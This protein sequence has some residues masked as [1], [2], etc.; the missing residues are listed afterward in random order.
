MYESLWSGLPDWEQISLPAQSGNPSCCTAAA[1]VA[2]LGRKRNLLQS[3]NPG[4]CNPERVDCAVAWGGF[5]QNVL[6]QG[7]G[8]VVTSKK[9][10]VEE[11]NNDN[12]I[13]K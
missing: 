9:T 6:E 4:Y 11:N 2:R 12:L 13:I 5:L 1:R 3:G 8:H 7:E 10:V